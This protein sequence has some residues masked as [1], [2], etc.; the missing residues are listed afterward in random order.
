MRP[1]RLTISAFGPY[2]GK[3]ELDLTGLGESGLYLISGDT[4]AGKTTLFDA[5]TYALYGEPSGTVRETSMLRSKYAEPGTETYVDLSFLYNGKEYNVVRKPEYKRAKKRG[6]GEVSQNADAALTYPD[7][8]VETGNK[9]VT[10]AVQEII[11]IVRSQFRQIAMIAQGDFLK[12]LISSTKER[13]DIFRRIFQT[14]NYETLQDRLKDE[15]SGLD[16]DH[17]EIHRSIKQH[18]AGIECA[19]DDVL[20]IDV[21]K[22]KAGDLSINAVLELLENL[23]KQDKKT[24]KKEKTALE[25]AEKEISEIDTALGKAEKDNKAREDLEKANAG[26][27]AAS[28]GTKEVQKTYDNAVKNQPE[29]EDLTG[30]IAKEEAKLPQ[31]D[32]LEKTGGEIRGK[33]RELEELREYNAGLE[34]GVVQKKEQQQEWSKE[35]AGLK[36]AETNKLKYENDH[37]KAVKK[38]AQV[39]GIKTLLSERAGIQKALDAAQSGY[40]KLRDIAETKNASYAKLSRAFLDAQAGILAGT[41]EDGEP[42]PVCGSTEHPALAALAVGAPTETDVE[43]AKREAEKARD[44]AASASSAAAEEKA[45]LEAKEKEMAKAAKDVLG[46]K[47][48]KLA[49]AVGAELSILDEA[50]AALTA[51]VKEERQRCER[52]ADIEKRQPILETELAEIAEEVTDSV[53]AIAELKTEIAGIEAAYKKIKKTLV[54]ETKKEAGENILSLTEKKKQLESTIQSAKTAVDEH[55]KTISGLETQIKTLNKQLDGAGATDTESLYSRKEELAERKA[56]LSEKAAITGSRLKINGD[57]EDRVSERLKE[58]TVVEERWKWVKALSDTANGQVAGKEKIMLETYVQ[59]YY[60]EQIIRNANLRLMTM[61]GGQYEL[62]RSA[63]A[64]NLRSQS[65]LDLN[66]IDHYN[67]SERSVK[68]LSGGESFMASLSLALGM[69]DEIQKMSGGI[70][71]DA[72]FVDEGFGSLDE[73]TLSQAM[74]ALID[75]AT[76]SNLLVGIISH[77]PELKERIDKQIVVKKGKSGGSRVEIVA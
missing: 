66:V 57:I 37:E 17:K 4:G 26:L 59:A 50:L 48:E 58:S 23:G 27:A 74:K 64:G 54:W 42:C 75:L 35:L 31:Y 30:R 45:K 69:S 29:I 76:E 2:A 24:Q 51:G 44:K 15:A 73:D 14:E 63:E 49:D 71:I 62:K 28:A 9:H 60:F 77:V 52:K 67:A 33:E 6:D 18:I 22:A 12:L 19:E 43:A 36:D 68:T 53:A 7:G 5:I 34:E 32:E 55:N 13:Q 21:R 70:R 72:M 11:G 1:L 38:K 40:L 65:G 41:L 61:S 25:K 56:E 39:S 16:R 10:E 46:V 3:T 20:E 47:P 8:R